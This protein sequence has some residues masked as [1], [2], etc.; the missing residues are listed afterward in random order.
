MNRPEVFTREV[1]VDISQIEWL[2]HLADDFEKD[3]DS[4]GVFLK[5]GM[6]RAL[7]FCLRRVPLD[8]LLPPTLSGG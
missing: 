4:G 3:A 6:L 7:A 2:G 1:P 8:P 5:P